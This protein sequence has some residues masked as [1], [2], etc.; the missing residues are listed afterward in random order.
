MRIVG[1]SL[2]FAML[3]VFA[4]TTPVVASHAARFVGP[5]LLRKMAELAIISLPKLV[6]HFALRIG[7]NLVELTARDEAFTQA[8]VID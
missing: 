6:A 5:A 1:A 2:I 7:S 4:L 3:T 8:G